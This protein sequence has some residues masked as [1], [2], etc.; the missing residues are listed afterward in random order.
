MLET[1][2]HE[3]TALSLTCTTDTHIHLLHM[4]AA[5]TRVSDTDFKNYVQYIAFDILSNGQYKHF[6]T[7]CCADGHEWAC[8]MRTGRDNVMAAYQVEVYVYIVLCR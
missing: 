8:S 6:V 2:I 7:T 1:S 4:A 5:C 3:H